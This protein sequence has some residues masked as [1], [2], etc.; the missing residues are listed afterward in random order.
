MPTQ[1]REAFVL[2][3]FDP[4]AGTA[5]TSVQHGAF[6]AR[7][8]QTEERWCVAELQRIKGELILREGAPDAAEVAEN[9]FLR[10]QRCGN[11]QGALSWELRC[12]TSLARLWKKQGRSFHAREMLYS[13]YGRFTEGFATAGLKT[14]KALLES[15]ASDSEARG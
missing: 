14:A 7:C 1:L 8:E 13:V 10:A 15:L 3:W 2:P 11:E 4:R 12:A 9:L 5:A 6:I